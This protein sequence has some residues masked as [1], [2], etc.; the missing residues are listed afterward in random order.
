MVEKNIQEDREYV[1]ALKIVLEVME[2]MKQ[3]HYLDNLKKDILST[4]GYQKAKYICEFSDTVIETEDAYVLV[5]EIEAR[6]KHVL[7]NF[8]KCI[9]NL[10]LLPSHL[11]K[12][13]LDKD[14]YYNQQFIEDIVGQMD[15]LIKQTGPFESF[16]LLVEYMKNY[17][18]A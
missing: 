15:E 11:Q 5:R 14:Y 3:Y 7:G 9:G 8:K 4:I 1:V 17:G 16:D 10:L 2:Q 13:F 12:E 18:N 6:M